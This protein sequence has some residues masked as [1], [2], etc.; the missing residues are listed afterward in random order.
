MAVVKL[1]ADSSRP[2][3]RN[4]HA[5]APTPI[6]ADAMAQHHRMQQT[7]VQGQGGY[8]DDIGHGTAP[9]TPRNNSMSGTTDCGDGSLHDFHDPQHADSEVD[10][11]E[12]RSLLGNSA[13]NRVLSSM[14]SRFSR[15]GMK[16]V[17]AAYQIIN[18]VILLLGFF[19]ITTGVVVYGGIFV[20]LAC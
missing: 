9:E 6:S 19:A 15:K 16:A 14:P 18:C 12:R 17:N 2:G 10:L 7:Y 8:S 3:Y 5:V 4:A 11:T 13:M 20:R 1:Y